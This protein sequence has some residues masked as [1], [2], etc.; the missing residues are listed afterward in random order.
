MAANRESG[1]TAEVVDRLLAGR[2]PAAV[3]ESG[4]LVMGGPGPPIAIRAHGSF[5]HAKPVKQASRE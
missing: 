1:I 2:D 3:F 5:R 4:G